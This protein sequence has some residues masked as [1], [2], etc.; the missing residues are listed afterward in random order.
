MEPDSPFSYAQHRANQVVVAQQAAEE[1][2]LRANLKLRLTEAFNEQA[3][4][5]RMCAKLAETAIK[6][7]ETYVGEGITHGMDAVS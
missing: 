6:V 3:V 1:A 5:Q 2:A 4:P 7:F